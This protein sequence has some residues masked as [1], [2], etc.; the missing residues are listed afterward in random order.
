MSVV[1]QWTSMPYDLSKGGVAPRTAQ[2]A[3]RHSSVDLTM[4][5][6]T[7]PKLLDV[8]GALEALPSMPLDGNPDERERATGTAGAGKPVS[9]VYVLCRHPP[10][11][12]MSKRVLFLTC[13]T[14]S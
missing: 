12:A 3:M 5:V 14:Q 1:A 2:A 9:I 7:D 6:Y 13:L 4:N 8:H 10:I 11:G